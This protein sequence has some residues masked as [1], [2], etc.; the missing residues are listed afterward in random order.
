MPTG[1]PN[2]G[3]FWKGLYHLYYIY[4]N[5]SGVSWAHVS[6]KD[7]VHWKWHPTTLMPLTMGHSMFSGTGFFTKQGRPAI[8]YH[9]EGSGRNQISFAEDDL[10]EKWSKPVPV[11]PKTRA[12]ALPEMRHWDPDCWLN[13]DTYYAVSGGR[14]PHL[15]KS[16]DLKN[17]SY[18]GHLLHDN[19]PNVGVP[20]DEDIT[21]M[22]QVGRVRL[23]QDEALT[24]S[25][26]TPVWAAFSAVEGSGRAG[27]VAC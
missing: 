18:L 23:D 5:K 21:P 15:M 9:G 22:D 2:G 26:H 3:F 10:L 6:S 13:G 20:R 17:W 25:D 8:I 14:D 7:M 12:G 4:I 16:T 27:G 19:M 24:V 1:D 11:E